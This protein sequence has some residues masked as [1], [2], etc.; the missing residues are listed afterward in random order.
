MEKRLLAHVVIVEDVSI[1]LECAIH[2]DE[3][4]QLLFGVLSEEYNS[5]VIPSRPSS[6]APKAEKPTL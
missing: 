1:R 3:A 4:R 2:P 6:R 5:F